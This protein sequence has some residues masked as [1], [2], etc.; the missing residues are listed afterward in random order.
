NNVTDEDR[1]TPG[2]LSKNLLTGLL[3]GE[4]GFN[5][6]IMTDATLMTGFGAHGRREDLVPMSIAN[7][8]DMFLFTKS[9]LEDYNFMLNGYKKGIITDE[10][11][12]DALDR[13]L[14]LKAHQKLNTNDNLVPGEVD[15]IGAS[16]HKAW[17]RKIADEGITL[18]QDNQGL[19][20][21]NKN[22]IKKI[23]IIPLGWDNDLFSLIASSKSLPLVVRLALKCKKPAPKKYQKFMEKMSREGFIFEEIDHTDLLLGMKQISQSIE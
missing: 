23:G 1:L 9:A 15:K 16:E 11:L 12:N 4:L 8:N 6:L 18:V 17:A 22:K 19:L 21:L 14:G 20:P 7:G 10:R 2:S 3:R 13:I 5:G